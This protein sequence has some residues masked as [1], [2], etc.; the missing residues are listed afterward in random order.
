MARK[1]PSDRRVACVNR[2][3]KH[4]YEIVDTVEAGLVLAGS[5]VKALREGKG[6]LTDA[7]VALA[8]L[9]GRQAEYSAAEESLKLAIDR[10]ERA[11]DERRRAI[12]QLQLISVA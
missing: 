4:D 2:R 7:Y 10:A 5:E 6:N 1:H 9:Q 11:Q 12:A 8:T 3:A